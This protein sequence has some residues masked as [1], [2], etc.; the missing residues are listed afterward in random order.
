MSYARNPILPGFLRVPPPAQPLAAV[1]PARM[2]PKADARLWPKAAE[3]RVGRTRAAAPSLLPGGSL[4]QPVPLHPRASQ[5]PKL[6]GFLKAQ[7][8]ARIHEKV[9]T[10]PVTRHAPQPARTPL[11]QILVEQGDLSPEDLARV[12]TVQARE[13]ARFGDILLAN[14][15]VTP[16]RLYAA[17]ARQYNTVVADLASDPP[18]VRLVDQIGADFCI[19]HGV[20]PWKRQGGGTV[21]ICSRP[22][23]FPRIAKV[24][25]ES[26]GRTYLAVAPEADIQLALIAARHRQLA[27]RAETRVN[28]HESCRA[29]RNGPAMR[30]MLTLI[31][32]LATV[33]V[34]SPFLGFALRPSRSTPAS[35]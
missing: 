8:P 29:W 24:L 35:S 7:T 12:I 14:S 16:Q 20:L 30:R 23:E 6:P 9:K 4:L 27:L 21:L 11:G 17:L 34:F 15:M 33:F 25:P 32:L 18:D 26:F 2:L 10:P 28:E 19:K 31:A 13:D 5:P 3:Q 22:D 1:P